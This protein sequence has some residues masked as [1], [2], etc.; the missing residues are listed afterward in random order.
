MRILP[1]IGMLLG[2]AATKIPDVPVDFGKT[3]PQ[4]VVPNHYFPCEPTPWDD[5]SG[6][7]SYPRINWLIG[8]IDTVS[9]TF[10]DGPD[11]WTACT[12]Y[13]PRELTPLNTVEY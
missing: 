5:Y 11:N 1:I 10:Y 12:I 3:V 9:V 4:A 7:M 2:F 6:W 8:S 13:L